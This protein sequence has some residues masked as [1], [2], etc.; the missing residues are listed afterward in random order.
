M[1]KWLSLLQSTGTGDVSLSKF[2]MFMG[3]IIG[4]AVVVIDA[5]KGSLNADIFA[6]FMFATLGANSVNKGIS[7]VQSIKGGS[8]ES[9][10]TAQSSEK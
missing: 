3:I 7:V 10:S 2:G 5:W 4:S 9:T 8:N 1:A 6:I